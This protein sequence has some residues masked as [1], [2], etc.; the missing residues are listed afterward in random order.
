MSFNDHQRGYQDGYQGAPTAPARNMSDA[1]GR[2]ED[3]ARRDAEV[4]ARQ[5]SEG[6]ENVPPRY[7]L[8]AILLLGVFAVARWSF[9]ANMDAAL[10]LTGLVVALILG[11]VAGAAYVY[12]RGRR[13]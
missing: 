13:S 2:G 12:G 6:Y 4:R 10:L 9:G 8:Y 3:Q 5:A 1:L 7:G 11:G